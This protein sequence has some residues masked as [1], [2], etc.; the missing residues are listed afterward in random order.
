ML[1]RPIIENSSIESLPS[2]KLD[3][4]YNLSVTTVLSPTGTLALDPT[5]GLP[6]PDSIILVWK[7]PASMLIDSTGGPRSEG[8]PLPLDFLDQNRH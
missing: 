2:L 4:P 6:S 1:S 7:I 8:R 5:G 3:C